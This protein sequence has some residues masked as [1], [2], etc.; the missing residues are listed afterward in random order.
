M[1]IA[2]AGRLG[3]VPSSIGVA[4][5]RLLKRVVCF[6]SASTFCISFQC[7]ICG[8]LYLWFRALIRYLKAFACNLPPWRFQ[9]GRLQKTRCAVDAF[10]MPC[11]AQNMHAWRLPQL[12]SSLMQIAWQIGRCSFE[13]W[14]GHF[15]V[16]DGMLSVSLM[17]L[18]FQCI[19]CGGLNFGSA[20]MIVEGTR[21]PPPPWRFQPGRLQKTRCAPSRRLF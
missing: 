5:F 18:H 1:Q 14:G 11:K 16:A 21:M 10:L 13:H 2:P 15:S 19:I 17:F 3:G 9:P 6:L 20:L 7:I 8:G 12:F 4:I